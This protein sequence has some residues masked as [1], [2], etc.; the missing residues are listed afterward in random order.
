ML[1]ALV[2]SLAALRGHD[3]PA[4]VCVVSPRVEALSQGDARG[5]VPLPLPQ[6]VVIEPLQE[7]RIERRGRLVW[8]REA[9]GGQ[10]LQGPLAW[11]VAAIAPGEEVLL[12]LRPR[13]APAGAFA[14]VELI[15]A[16]A[17]R[18]Q[19][20]ETLVAGLAA[21][22]AAWGAA[23]EAAL[24]A[25]DVPLAW[26]LLFHPRIPTDPELDSLRQEVI[27]RGCGD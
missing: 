24:V 27:Q 22:P 9:R 17:D 23:I 4:A 10:W 5:E 8:R 16:Q 6:L 2:L 3:L 14:H 1:L 7:I 21:Q 20:A 13:L 11:P 19:A 25:E 15:G 18:M 26:A 12:R